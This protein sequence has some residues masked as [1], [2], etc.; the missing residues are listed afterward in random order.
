MHS[1][2]SLAPVQ[3]RAEDEAMLRQGSFDASQ[4]VR[5]RSVQQVVDPNHTR[6]ACEGAA[7][8][9]A[10]AAA[11]AGRGRPPPWLLAHSC[12]RSAYRPV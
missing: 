2:C 3:D 7:P 4:Q 10:M 12:V 1:Y 5:A 9:A 11:D 8:D 6:A